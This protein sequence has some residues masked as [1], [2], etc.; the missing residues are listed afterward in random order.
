MSIFHFADDERCLKDVLLHVR[1]VHVSRHV[2][3]LYGWVNFTGIT[4]RGSNLG[5][6]CKGK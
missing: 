6:M 1:R 2:G 3:D 4:R 5:V